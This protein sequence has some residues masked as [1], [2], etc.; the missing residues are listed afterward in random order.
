MNRDVDEAYKLSGGIRYME[1][2][3]G[4]AQMSDPLARC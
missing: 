3:V 2:K 4:L 1:L